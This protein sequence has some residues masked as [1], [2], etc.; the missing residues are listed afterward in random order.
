MSAPEPTCDHGEDTRCAAC[1]EPRVLSAG[2]ALMEVQNRRMA[3]H[4]REQTEWR[5]E[6]REGKRV[7]RRTEWKPRAKFM[8]DLLLAQQHWARVVLG[9]L[10]S[11]QATPGADL[12]GAA[13]PAATAGEE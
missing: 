1:F 4:N 7:T 8:G 6:I 9:D 11:P 2:R 12:A 3:Y 5:L 10:G 13:A